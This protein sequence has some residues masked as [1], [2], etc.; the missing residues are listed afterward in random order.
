MH[1]EPG[2]VHSPSC[3]DIPGQGRSRS[4]RCPTSCCI[5]LLCLGPARPEPCLCAH[6]SWNQA[7]RPCGHHCSELVR[8][9]L[10]RFHICLTN[11]TQSA[12]CW[13]AQHLL[14]SHFVL[15]CGYPFL[16]DAHHGVLAARAIITPINYRLTP[17][18]V[19]YILDHS[20][21]NLVIVDHEYQHLVSKAFVDKHGAGAVIVSQDTGRA[22]DPYEEFLSSGRRFSGEKGWLGLDVEGDEDA[23][24]SLC[25][26]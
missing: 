18:E 9:R 1:K 4:P 3:S 12:H 11:Q 2:R 26:T 20:G 8:V 10:L 6:S 5:H 22:G 14:V 21:S 13:Q 16:T 25:Y 23:G 24:A 7:G 19:A 17:H 15:T